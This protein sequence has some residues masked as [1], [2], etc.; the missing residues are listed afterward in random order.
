[1]E[2]VP[3]NESL[4]TISRRY[5]KMVYIVTRNVVKSV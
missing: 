4:R 3:S 5:F 1:M 2:K